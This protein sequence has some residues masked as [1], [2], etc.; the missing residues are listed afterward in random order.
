MRR[1]TSTQL[2][3]W[4]PLLA[5]TLGAAACGPELGA[6]E[7]EETAAAVG[8]PAPASAP[9]HAATVKV[10]EASQPGQF[11]TGFNLYSN[12]GQERA[13]AVTSAACV[14]GRSASQ[15]RVQVRK[16]ANSSPWTLSALA[17]YIHPIH[18]AS[19]APDA[20]ALVV[21]GTLARGHGS[22]IPQLR[23]YAIDALGIDRDYSFLGDP[24]LTG[25]PFGFGASGG[26]H[27]TGPGVSMFSAN[28]GGIGA[29]FAIFLNRADA[30]TTAST[31]M[32]PGDQ[33]A[34][35][36]CDRLVGGTRVASPLIGGSSDLII[37][38][39]RFGVCGMLIRRG[40]LGPFGEVHV[41]AIEISPFASWF[42]TV[43]GDTCA[44]TSCTTP[45]S[46]LSCA[47]TG[48]G[49]HGDGCGGVLNCGSCCV[50]RTCADVSYQCGLHDDGCGGSLNC[51]SCR[52]RGEELE[53][54]GGNRLCLR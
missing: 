2:H 37:G 38:N 12:P 13:Y 47:E 34:P 18:L 29:R 36:L 42:A 31:D 43:H 28:P 1:R 3:P 17:V 26:V 49:E 35:T 10:F 40:P 54:C 23:Y 52:T 16:D 46:P 30:E 6:G 9:F 14:A 7:L 22:I 20:P 32:H 44:G 50:P 11:C 21:Y 53:S 41:D 8:L 39:Q 48:C 19:G 33:G 15:L 5:L 27:V 4:T 24:R 25:Y 45:C 51:G